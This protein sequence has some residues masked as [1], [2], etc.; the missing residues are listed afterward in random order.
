VQRLARDELFHVDAIADRE[1]RA[2]LLQGERVS[3]AARG[4]K[5]AQQGLGAQGR[6]GGLDE[7][8]DHRGAARQQPALSIGHLDV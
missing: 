1:R 6:R 3:G 8:V 7:Q 2:A 4:G 5:A